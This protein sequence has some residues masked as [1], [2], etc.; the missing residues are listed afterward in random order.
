MAVVRGIKTGI[1]S[2]KEALTHFE[3]NE[4]EFKKWERAYHE[5]LYMPQYTSS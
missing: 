4:E 1:L 5:M 3:M 2:K